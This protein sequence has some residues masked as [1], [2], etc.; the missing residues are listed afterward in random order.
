[1]I[2]LNHASNVVGTLLPIAGSGC[3]RPGNTTCFSWW[4]LP[5]P[6]GLIRWIC[7]NQKIDLLGF[8]GHKSLYGPMGTGGL[9]LGERVEHLTNETLETRRN[10]QPFRTR[11]STRLS[12]RISSKAEPPMPSGWP[13]SMLASIGCCG[14]EWTPF[15]PVRKS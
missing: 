10:R 2:A 5:R 12:C 1:M 11:I 7:K 4:I 15:V 6:A 3:H 8:T 14:R 9:I 13:G